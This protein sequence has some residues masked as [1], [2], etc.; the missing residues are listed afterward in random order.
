LAEEFK[1]S[2]IEILVATM[3]RRSLDFLVPMFPGRHYFEFNILI[4]NQTTEDNIAQSDYAS[5][6]VINV[7]DK[8]LS[9]SRN[10]A[11]DNA[12]GKLC[13]ITDDDVVFKTDFCN[14]ITTAFNENNAAA[15]ISFR[16]EKAEGVLYKKYPLHRLTTTKQSNR[17][18]IMSIEMVIDR[19]KVQNA[20]LKFNE[21]F[22]L[23]AQFC[24]GEEAIFLHDAKKL[25][26]GLV[27]EP[28]VIAMHSAQDT[29]ERIG[30]WDKYFVQ[31]A[32]FTALLND[33][34][35]LLVISKL[36]HEIRRNKLK[37]KQVRVAIKAVA[38]GRA[39]FKK[40]YENN[41]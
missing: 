31:G 33:K 35:Y 20:N 39:A 16:V 14:H 29:H 12:L 5:V 30:V 8:G 40:L 10:L 4:I 36:A 19:E 32:L 13:V 21:H 41:S 22:G 27:M 17:L 26:L 23:G 38:A 34:Y 25:G 18:N 7:F 11:L 15:L 28:Q 1:N 2:D 3:N 9:K 24:M 6:R 37:L